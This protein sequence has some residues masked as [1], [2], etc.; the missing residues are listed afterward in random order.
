M[1]ESFIR[2]PQFYVRLAGVFYLAIIVLGLFGESYVRS[3]LMVAGDA[4][5]TA[6]NIANSSSLWRVGIFSD[7]MMQVLDIPIRNDAYQ[8]LVHKS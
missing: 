8:A 6:Q 1:M 4:V 2:S 3:N 7:L 5:A